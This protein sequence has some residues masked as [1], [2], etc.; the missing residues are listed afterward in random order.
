MKVLVTSC[1]AFNSSTEVCEPMYPAPPV[2]NTFIF[3]FSFKLFHKH[4]KIFQ[5]LLRLLRLS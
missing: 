4:L 1:P 3:L 5:S 2:T